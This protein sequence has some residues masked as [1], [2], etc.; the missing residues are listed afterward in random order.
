[1]GGG[2]WNDGMNRVGI[3]GTGESVWLAWFLVATLRRFAPWCDARAD[4]ARADRYRRQAEDYRTAVEDHAWDGDWYLRAFFDDG[5]PLGTHL[6][7]EA[8]VD[9]IAQSWSVLSGAADP[10]RSA[11]AM[12]SLEEHLVRMD[13]GIVLLL[14]PPFDRGQKDPGYIKGYLPGVREN[15]GQYTHAAIWAAWA[16]AE[17]G[18]GALAHRLFDLLN[19]VRHADTPEAAQRYKVEPYVIAADVYGV[20]PHIGRGGWTWYTGSA[21]W[22]YRLGIEAILGLH[23]HGDALDIQPCIPNGWDAFDVDYRYG[24][25][26]YQIHVDN[27]HH[28][29]RGVEEVLVDGQTLPTH[30]VPLRDDGGVHSVRIRMGRRDARA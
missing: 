28:C 14:T 9:S 5:T 22:M 21:A 27:P 7:D 12:A 1:M 13:D 23:R 19:P 15:G 16:F 10:Q 25:S 26:S 6:A 3:G 11:R 20:A 18:D 30:R 8:K 24:S 4:T 2:D 29:A 17:L